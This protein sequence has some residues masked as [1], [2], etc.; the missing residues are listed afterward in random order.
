[1]A[2]SKYAHA[3]DEIWNLG[4]AG[5]LKKNQPIGKIYA[6][7]KVDKYVPVQYIPFDESSKECIAST[8]P[9]HHLNSPGYKLI[10]SDFPIHNKMLKESLSSHW[11][12]VDMEGYGIAFAAHHLDKTCKMWK[13]ISDFASE[14][15]RDLIHKHMEELSEIIADKIEF[16]L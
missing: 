8:I 12:L 4:V 15:G 13:V 9:S 6:I 16:E 14:N 2:V 5:S 10:S 3:F 7:E 11:D 1:M